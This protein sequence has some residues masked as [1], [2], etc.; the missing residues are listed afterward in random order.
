MELKVKEVHWVDKNLHL[1]LEDNSELVLADAW[2]SG[3]SSN[4]EGNAI[5]KVENLTYEKIGILKDE[6]VYSKS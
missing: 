3:Y 4:M 5:V 6:S 1:K 2:F